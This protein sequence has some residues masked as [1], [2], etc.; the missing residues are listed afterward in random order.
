MHPSKAEL[1]DSPPPLTALILKIFS[2]FGFIEVGVN[3]ETGKTETTNLTILNVF[4]VR[5]GPM[6]EDKLVKVL[7][8]TQV[9]HC[10]F[11][12]PRSWAYYPL[13]I[14][15]AG[16]VVAFVIRYGLAWLLYDGNRR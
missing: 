2:V 11:M 16:S 15:I 1:K 12:F 14:Q 6:R 4:L 5:L 9:R 7:I 10:G 8:S 3:K 13:C